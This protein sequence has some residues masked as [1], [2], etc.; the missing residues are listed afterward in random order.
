MNKRRGPYL[1]LKNYGWEGWA[2]YDYNSLDEALANTNF[3][4]GDLI[5]KVLDVKVVDPENAER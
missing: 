4:E 2:L 3:E 1:V 5:V